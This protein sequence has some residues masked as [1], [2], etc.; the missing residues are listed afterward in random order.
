MDERIELNVERYL[1]EKEQEID[2]LLKDYNLYIIA[3]P[4]IGKTFQSDIWAAKYKTCLIEPMISTRDGATANLKNLKMIETKDLQGSIE[5]DSSVVV[6]WDTFMLM[7]E[8][9]L[10]KDFDLIILDESHEII[11]QS[12]FRDKAYEL[13][14]YFSK[15]RTRFIMMT[16][17]PMGEIALFQNMKTVKINAPEQRTLKFNTINCNGR[18]LVEDAILKTAKVCCLRGAKTIYYSNSN[19]ALQ[20]RITEKL[21]SDHKIG[22]YS[23]S[24]S[25]KD[26]EHLIN[27]EE[28][29]GDYDL[30]CATSYLS[31]GVNIKVN[32]DEEAAIIVTDERDMTPMS[33]MQIANRFRDTDL[34]IFYVHNTALDN[35]VK[36]KTLNELAREELKSN[37]GVNLN[38]LSPYL[39]SEA[40]KLTKRTALVEVKTNEYAIDGQRQSIQEIYEAVKKLTSIEFFKAYFKEMKYLLQEVEY[41]KKKVAALRKKYDVV[42]FIANNIRE[43]F[44]VL[45]TISLENKIYTK[46]VLLEDR[47]GRTR[48]EDGVIKTQNLNLFNST[49]RKIKK[50]LKEG[51]IMSNIVP[52]LKSPNTYGKLDSWYRGIDMLSRWSEDFEETLSN[53][54]ESTAQALVKNRVIEET[55]QLRDRFPKTIEALIARETSKIHDVYHLAQVLEVAPQ[56]LV[57]MFNNMKDPNTAIYSEEFEM[58]KDINDMI[59]KK[60]KDKKEKISSTRKEVSKNPCNGRKKP[61]ELYKDGVLFKEFESKIDAIAYLGVSRSKFIKTDTITIDGIKYS[62]IVK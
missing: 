60:N 11:S 21:I 22:F 7:L 59:Q 62:I 2:K 12:N 5:I 41:S 52:I 38:W 43:I 34:E 55:E 49:I 4:G 20:D 61:C 54:K 17:T 50:L 57:D 23:S 33:L 32:K 39:Q 58:Y 24:M 53:I 26:L 14:D 37:D 47:T 48:I 18:L 16:G 6:I 9:G 19:R 15:T 36:E 25:D 28:T 29:F 30:V 51:V 45:S 3:K 1:S 42:P 13:V 56:E 8:K 27:K 40:K 44:D 10:V 31:V 35:K 46:D